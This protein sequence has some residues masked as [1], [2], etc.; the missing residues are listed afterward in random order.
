MNKQT[1]IFFIQ[2][3]VAGF[4]VTVRYEGLKPILGKVQL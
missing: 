2:S 1:D 3:S 4:N